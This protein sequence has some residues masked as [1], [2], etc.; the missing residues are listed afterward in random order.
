[1]SNTTNHGGR[2]LL[3]NLENV[4]SLAHGTGEKLRGSLNNTVD[5]A[6][7][8]RQGQA[9]NA[10][11]IERGNQE[12]DSGRLQGSG[13][14]QRREEGVAAATTAPSASMNTD[15]RYAGNAAP[16]RTT[17]TTTTTT[18]VPPRGTDAGGYGGEHSTAL[19]G[20]HEATF[21]K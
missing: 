17:Q 14:K 1:M 20:G 5:T 19:D 12:I 13:R 16:L 21:R 6:V 9:K 4:A 3:S 15:A 7:N 10:A 2:G 8:D 11:T 18:T